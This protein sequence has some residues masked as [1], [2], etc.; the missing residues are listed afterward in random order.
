MSDATPSERRAATTS[1]GDLV[2]EVTRD[3]ST[4]MRQE[5][6]LAKAEVKDS[7]SKSA[8]G[9]G[10][11]GGAGYAAG[12][13]VLF[14]SIALWAALALVVGSAWSAVVVAVLWAIIAGILFAI[15]RA[16]LKKVQGVPQTAA[17]LQEIP[18]AFTR[19]EENR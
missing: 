14:L 17:T 6:A 1:L 11:L 15:G 8:K 19:N 13:V 4:L 18:E 9:A 3:M 2:G 10:L 5:L 7:A 12:M 16:Q